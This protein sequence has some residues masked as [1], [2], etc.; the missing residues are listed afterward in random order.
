MNSRETGDR[1]ETLV[2]YATEIKESI[3]GDF[4]LREGIEIARQDFFDEV[5]RRFFA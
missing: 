1:A 5:A 4:T 3:G 2:P